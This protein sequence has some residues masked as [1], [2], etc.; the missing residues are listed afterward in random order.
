MDHIC[1]HCDEIIVGNAY[2]VTSEENGITLLDI[3]VCAVCAA[4]AKSLQLHIR[5][6]TQENIETLSRAHRSRFC[7]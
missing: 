1:E 5:V 7:A 2:Q 4:E 6:I 3:I